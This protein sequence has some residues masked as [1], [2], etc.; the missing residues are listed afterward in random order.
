MNMLLALWMALA[1]GDGEAT[2]LLDSIA[3]EHEDW[4]LRLE[5]GI[6]GHYFDGALNL[7]GDYGPYIQAS[8]NVFE[9]LW[10]FGE[11]RH[12]DTVFEV[13]GPNPASPGIDVDTWLFGLQGIRPVTDISYIALRLGAG[14]QRYEVNAPGGAE[15]EEPAAIAGISFLAS[16]EFWYV[17]IGADAEYTRTTFNQPGGA[18]ETM[19]NYVL[20][21]TFGV[22]F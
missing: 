10:L 5:L 6:H 7:A 2:P 3:L 11:F 18:K 1:P 13:P 12:V 19:I 9:R 4:R 20:A 15:V 22:Q 14:R 8:F 17:R 16:E 21:F